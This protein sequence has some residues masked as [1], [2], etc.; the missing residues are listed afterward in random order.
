MRSQVYHLILHVS[1]TEWGDDLKA[2]W[3]EGLTSRLGPLNLI[4]L[5]TLHKAQQVNIYRTL[6]LIN[7]VEDR[8]SNV[9]LDQNTHDGESIKQELLLLSDSKSSRDLTVSVVIDNG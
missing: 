7:A 8:P 4:C 9:S 6:S 2:Q 5:C 3:L 1:G